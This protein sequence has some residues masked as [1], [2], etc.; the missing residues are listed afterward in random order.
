M[1]ALCEEEPWEREAPREAG[2]LQQDD[3]KKQTK[4]EKRKAL[5]RPFQTGCIYIGKGVNAQVT[6]K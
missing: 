3:D 5:F 1:A 2:R 4:D 6:V